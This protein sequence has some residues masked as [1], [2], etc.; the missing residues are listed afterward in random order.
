MKI[1]IVSG[2][3]Q[4]GQ[5]FI[6][7]CAA[8]NHDLAATAFKH[9]EYI[10]KPYQLDLLD[11]EATL[12][13][14]RLTKPDVFCLISGL[15]TV[16]EC[17]LDPNRAYLLNSKVPKFIAEE[18]GT[19]DSRMVYISS[20]Y[21][22]DGTKASYSEQDRPSP[23]NIYGL[24]KLE[25][26]SNVLG[27]LAKDA[28]V[29]RTIVVFGPD[30]QFKNFSSQVLLSLKRMQTFAASVDQ[31]S[32]PIYNQNLSDIMLA[33]IE[34]NASGIYNVAGD[35][36]VSRYDLAKKISVQY[37]SEQGLVIPKSTDSKS[38]TNRRPLNTVLNTDKLKHLL[39]NLRILSLENGISKTIGW[40]R[41]QNV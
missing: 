24:S 29:I 27:V 16:Q 28:L 1:C 37:C 31:I 6:Q 21:V 5:A 3:G 33:L 25:G 20:G 38:S 39:P 12:K 19:I 8:S 18:L 23:I 30:K 4:I 40:F 15:N 9:T 34:N 36:V 14:I 10:D 13:F 26:E 2:S 32:N 35:D 11:K 17:E 41:K 7:S 22:F